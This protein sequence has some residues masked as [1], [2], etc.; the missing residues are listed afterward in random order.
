[1]SRPVLRPRVP[2]RLLAW[3][4][5][6]L[7]ALASPLAARAE[8][9][10]S[11]YVEGSSN[12]KA[13]EIFNGTGA[14]IDL[15]VAGYNVQMFFNG[16]ASAGLTINLTGVVAA[17]DVFIVA[18]SSADAAILAV[19]DQTNGAGWFNGDDAIVL[20]KGTTVIDSLGQ[21]GTD[22]GTEWGSGL[23][24][25]ADNTLRRKADVCAGDTVTS[26]AF[27]PATEW[28]GFATNTFAGLGAHDC[29]GGE[30]P[31]PPP[32]VQEKEI[33]QIQGAGLASPLAGQTVKTLD[34]IVTGV[35]S[36]G[37]F[38]QTPEA[39]VDADAE[40]SNGIFV[41]TGSAPAVQVGDQVDVTGTVAEFFNFTEI[42][43]PTVTVD[44]TG[45]AL[46]AAVLLDADTPSPDQPQPATEM[47]RYEG[48]IVRV[49][50]GIASGPT[51]RFG[52][53]PV[54]A[55]PNRPFRE[56]GILFPGEPGLPVW[57]GNPEI[58]EIN[59]D[60]AGLPNLDIPAGAVI[61]VA[62]G[63]LSFSFSD[64][65]IW[66]TTLS[67]NGTIVLDPIRARQAGELT[68]ASQNLLRLMDTVN[69]PCSDDVPTPAVYA[70]R[71]NK[72]SL[73]IR[74][75]FGAPD[76]V[77]VQ[78]VENLG[79][80]QAVAA[81]ILADDPAIAYDAYLLEGNDV[82]CIDIGF[83]VR[84]TI[85]VD[86]VT[87]FGKDDLFTFG[88]STALL[89]DRPPL[90]LRGSYVGNG[91]PF[92]IT[93]IGIHNRSLSGIDGSDG[94]RVRAK[95]HEQALRISQ[96]VQSLQTSEPGIRLVLTGDF[97]AFQ[98]TDGYVD[99]IGQITGSPDP[100]GAMIPATDEVDPDLTNWLLSEP[101][102][103]R[104]SF[105]FDGSAQ[106]LDHTLTTQ[107]LDPFVRGLEHVRGNA[108]APDALKNDPNTALR[109]ADHDGLAL[110]VMS[111]F[112]ADGVAD[113]VD[114]CRVT[115][116]PGQED[117]DGDGVGDS[118]D[119]CP[120]TPNPLQLD[121]DHDG[122]ADECGDRCAGTVAPESVPTSGLKPN[123]YAL[124]DG[125]WTF[126]TPAGSSDITVQQTAGCSCE[127]IIVEMGLG[128]GHRK[129]G[130]SK[131]AMEDWILFVSQ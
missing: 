127:Q 36:N 95:R 81:R 48:M 53:T 96:Y 13:L 109:T 122:V 114:N 11:E 80:L 93:V 91:A 19:A 17:G 71:L 9:L 90:V 38:I 31:P 75:G 32:P 94:A 44:S 99:A 54:V 89:H 5:P 52:D 6:C 123:H 22:P 112:D 4:L 7:L 47:E 105:I 87:Q 43:G 49:E 92:P 58:F 117:G 128:N 121:A 119:N 107:A 84:D 65:Q 40:T 108:D 35:A 37:F 86:S 15:G 3:A 51:D 16:S 131:G 115:A 41:F 26:D 77:V 68:I 110:F 20:R 28:D 55:G 78:E 120:T 2:G 33:W 82:G 29:E 59:P 63:P 129:N 130:C 21:I 18:H 101:A 10:L 42:D 69:D 74:E 67:V 88:T 14:A 98:F 111:D 56:P 50:N 116:N 83:L 62:E 104:Y 70:D 39:R 79:V 34:N 126:D 60:G 8:L 76:I 1:M 30:E 97:N 125:D 57:D 124:V 61:D 73:L 113:D 118:C 25:T 23:A 106:A 12:N 72:V 66:P 24:S 85:Q 27:D 100:L 103:E 45:N 46:P 64:Y 102:A